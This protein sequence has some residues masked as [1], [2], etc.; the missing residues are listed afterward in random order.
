MSAETIHRS[1]GVYAEL[2][3]SPPARAD[4]L[5]NGFE[6][7]EPWAAEMANIAAIDSSSFRRILTIHSDASVAEQERAGR[8]LFDL[9]PKSPAITAIATWEC[10]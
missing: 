5:L 8:S 3:G 10:S 4:L 6:P 1:L 7:G 2:H 9:D